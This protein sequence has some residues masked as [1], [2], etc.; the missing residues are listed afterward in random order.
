[1][2]KI[3][4]DLKNVGARIAWNKV[5]TLRLEKKLT[6]VQLSAYS[7][8]A[9]ATIWMIENGYDKTTSKRTKQRL[10]TFFKCNVSDLFPVEMIGNQTREEYIKSKQTQKD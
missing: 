4:W 1:M 6:Q 8:V 2:S 10:A 3:N 5:K 9:I 7:G